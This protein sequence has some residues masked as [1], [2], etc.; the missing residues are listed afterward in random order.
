MSGAN[1]GGW[2]FAFSK[3][4]LGYLA[5]AIAFAIACGFLSNWQLARSKEAAAANALISQNFDSKPVPLTS[6]LP[7]LTSYSKGQEWTRVTVTGTYEPD[8]QLLARNRP[9][10]GNPGFEVLTPLRTADGSLFI[11]DR[12]WV[13][14]GN[15][16]DDPDHVPAPPSGTVTVVARL[17]ASEPAIDGRTAVGRQVGTIQLSVVK[18]KMDTGAVYTGAYGLLDSEKPAPASA[19]TPTVTEPPTQDEGLHWS[20]MIQWIIFALIGFFGLGYALRTEYRKLNENDPAEK[21]R[22]AERDRKRAL[23]RTDSDVEDELLDAS[24]R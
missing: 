1:G 23:K 24:S 5:F 13:P 21:A 22:A 12:G 19:P 15:D 6:E 10:N 16:S 3:R 9:F 20:Y 8:L 7:T 18:Q 14:T 17:K 2:K 11:V 4:W